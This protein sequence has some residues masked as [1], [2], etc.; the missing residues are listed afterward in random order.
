MAK[1]QSKLIQTLP[2]GGGWKNQVPGNSRASSVHATKAE[3]VDRGRA[4]AK[5]RKM[6]HQIHNRDGRIGVKNSYGNDPYP[7]KG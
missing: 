4:M 1:K 2:S 5:A 6:E 3:A 7:P